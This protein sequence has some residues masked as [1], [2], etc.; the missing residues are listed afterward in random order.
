[1]PCHGAI[2]STP[3]IDQ[4]SGTIYV[5][6]LT[7]AS[8][9]MVFRLRALD[10]TSGAE[11]LGGPVT[12]SATVA[13][14]GSGS[15]NGRITF[16]SSLELQ[17]PALLLFNGT[18]YVGFARQK[19]E[20]T[21]P[22]HGW[23]LGYDAATLKQTYALNTTLNGNEGGIWMS[24]RGPAADG[25]GFTFITGNGDVGNRNIGE[26]FARVASNNLRVVFTDPNWTALNAGDF[27]LGAGGPLLFPGTALLAGGGKAGTLYLLQITNPGALQLTQTVQATFGCPGSDP[28]CAQIHHLALWNRTGSR[29]PLLYLW[30]STVM[31]HSRPSAFRRVC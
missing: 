5:V 29:P 11:K 30:A 24:G 28:S 15:N 21:Y 3:V 25:H 10:V 8:D 23:L 26:S 31:T 16:N 1:M 27:D 18:V 2:L 22:F 20:S 7:L 12:I 17:R 13:G 4:S 9:K 19:S 14:T 6:A